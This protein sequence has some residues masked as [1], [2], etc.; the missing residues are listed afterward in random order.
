M[1]DNDPVADAL[2]SGASRELIVRLARWLAVT[3]GLILI[4]LALVTFVS[5]V[6]RNIWS[7]AVPGDYELVEYGAGLAAS[8]FLPLA[9]I[10]LVHP[11]IT[12]FSERFSAAIRQILDALA[13]CIGA[14]VSLLLAVQ[15][16]RGAWDALAFADQS[17]ILRLPSWVGVAVLA[18]ALGLAGLFALYR[19]VRRAPEPA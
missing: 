15:L 17:M 4:A 16:A 3:G 14:G 1:P 11:R 5:I 9:Q 10:E 13:L 2:A 12:F 6:G 18:A 19:L 8:L 7:A